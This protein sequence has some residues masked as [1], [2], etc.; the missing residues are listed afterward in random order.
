VL[1]YKRVTCYNC[2]VVKKRNV[3]GWIFKRSLFLSA[4]LF[5]FAAGCQ[6]TAALETTQ[7]SVVETLSALS[8]REAGLAA[9]PSALAVAEET[10]SALSTQNAGQAA[11]ISTQGTAGAALS[12]QNATL[13]DDL[14]TQA[15]I[16]SYLATRPA[17]IITPILPGSTPT[18]YRPVL[19]SLVIED[20]HCC[21][22]GK[23]G[24][25]I[26]ITVAFQASSPFGEVTEMRVRQGQI[27]LSEDELG[28]VEWEPFAPDKIYA[29]PVAINWVGHFVTVQFRD[30]QGNLSPVYHDDIAVEGMP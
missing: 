7:V 26:E 23:A 20:G 12:T 24:E 4:A 1:R 6:D 28:D 18:P 3:S 22:S 21:A 16:I 13:A 25:T 19:G 30:A 15:A 8:T 27:P 29:V 17:I 5:I 14:S 2:G 10:I 9:Q 11:E